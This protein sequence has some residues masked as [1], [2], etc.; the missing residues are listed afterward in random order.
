[1]K[2][3]WRKGQSALEYTLILG[4]VI[5]VVVVVLLG[6]SGKDRSADTGLKNKIQRTYEKAG[7]A[8]EKTAAD[9]EGHGVFK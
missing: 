5:T 2:R 6:V 9:V 1:M 3:S 8:V 7:Q 4:A